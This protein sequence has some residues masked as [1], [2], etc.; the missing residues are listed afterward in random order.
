[1]NRDAS[2]PIEPPPLTWDQIWSGLTA[3][4]FLAVAEALEAPK[5]GR[6]DHL[7]KALPG[8]DADSIVVALSSGDA[9]QIVDS[10]LR[11]DIAY[12]RRIR[13]HRDAQN[14][15]R[16]LRGRKAGQLAKVLSGRDPE[17][18]VEAFRSG[19]E[20]RI[21]TA[22][23]TRTKRGGRRHPLSDAD[24]RRIEAIL[25]DDE[26]LARLSQDLVRQF[27]LPES[28][29]GDDEGFRRIDR[30]LDG[31]DPRG[32]AAAVRRRWDDV[33]HGVRTLLPHLRRR[34]A[35][36]LRLPIARRR[37][38]GQADSVD[39]DVSNSTLASLLRM[40][41]DGHFGPLDINSRQ[42]FE[43]Y[44]IAIIINK[45]KKWFNE[46]R[47]PV[48]SGDLG[49]TAARGTAASSPATGPRGRARRVAMPEGH[50]EGLVDPEAAE[51]PADPQAAS[52]VAIWKTAFDDALDQILGP[53]D[54]V[55]R[56]ILHGRVYCD[57]QLTYDEIARRVVAQCGYKR[58]S[59]SAARVRWDRLKKRLQDGLGRAGIGP[60]P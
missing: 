30:A 46:Y 28:L 33:W 42:D 60:I 25:P 50:A 27:P 24:A 11:L 53:L 13:D 3:G 41:E 58:Y 26:A 48:A 51:D 18:I 36:K 16:A 39:G 55:D 17:S 14:V 1:M 38:G 2:S 47:P 32:L 34:V 9:E 6:A 20:D 59:E 57:P 15:G 7:A 40:A 29:G 8:R 45:Y 5:E 21:V 4:G 52:V 19:D 37:L 12:L 43:N 44:I 35:R 49:P 10:L 31:H 54:S 56:V 23:T 22:L